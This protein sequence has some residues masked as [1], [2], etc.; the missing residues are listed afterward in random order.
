M[1]SARRIAARRILRS[2]DSH[3]RI[4]GETKR[5]VPRR[6]RRLLDYAPLDMT[7]LLDLDLHDVAD[8]EISRRFHRDRDAARRAGRN[9]RAGQPREPPPQPLDP[10]E[11]I[12]NRSLR[13][14]L[15]PLLA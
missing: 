10:C 6:L 13:V 14:P 12:A 9:D 11:A 5:L 7:D 15:L 4:I 8:L 2:H 1:H 3:A